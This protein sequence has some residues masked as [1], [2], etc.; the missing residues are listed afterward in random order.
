M[1]AKFGEKRRRPAR[2]IRELGDD[3]RR[4]GS[5]PSTGLTRRARQTWWCARTGRGC[6][7]RRRHGGDA[8]VVLGGL[9]GRRRRWGGV[10]GG[11]R[12]EKR[13]LLGFAGEDKRGKGAGGAVGAVVTEAARGS[14][15]FSLGEVDDNA[16]KTYPF[17]VAGPG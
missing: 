13:G 5:I 3:T 1:A 12:G 17:V 8:T 16:G 11:A 10:D 2:G 15:A 6:L 4:P 9:Q 14:R 7:E